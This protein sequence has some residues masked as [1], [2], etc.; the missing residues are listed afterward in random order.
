VD[1]LNVV[2]TAGEKAGL[3]KGLGEGVLDFVALHA[4]GELGTDEAVDGEGGEAEDTQGEGDLSNI[5]GL[6]TELNEAAGLYPQHGDLVG[7]PGERVR[8]FFEVF[9]IGW[10]ELVGVEAVFD[11]IVVATLAA[12]MAGNGLS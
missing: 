2:R 9:E 10:V 6:A 3:V 8:A 7:K 5:L 1:S 12:A 4:E 11:G